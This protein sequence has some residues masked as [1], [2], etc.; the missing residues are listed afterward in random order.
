MPWRGKPLIRH[1]AELIDSMD[2][3]QFVVVLGSESGSTESLLHDLNCESVVNPEWAQGQGRSTSFGVKQLQP[4]IDAAIFFVAD[5]P[6]ISKNLVESLIEAGRLHNEEIIVPYCQGKRRN[7]VL[8]KRSTFADLA[9]L[10]AEQGGRSIF[11]DHSLF[12]MEWYS[13]EEF[14]DVDTLDDYQE[15]MNQDEENT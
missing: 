9:K 8:F 5:Q 10:D 15:I 6:K 4:I 2:F 11:P 14:T 1:A 13:Q 3:S 12:E 7:P